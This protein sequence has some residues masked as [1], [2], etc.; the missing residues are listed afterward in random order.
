MNNIE[1]TP[2]IESLEDLDQFLATCSNAIERITAAAPSDS[3]VRMA[4][5]H[6]GSFYLVRVE[7]ISTQVMLDLEAQA[8]S[9]FMALENVLK[10]SLERISKWS[11]SR[12]LQTA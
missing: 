1:I 8:V 12:K 11:A 7:L 2:N 9:P 6:D 3:S 5:D 4:L 10:T